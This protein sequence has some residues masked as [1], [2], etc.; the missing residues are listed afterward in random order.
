MRLALLGNPVGHSRSPAMHHAALAYHGVEGVYDA[1]EVDAAQFASAVSEIAVGTLTGVNVTMPHK[2]L[3]YAASEVVSAD[4]AM[5]RSV[6]TM[7]VRDQ[8]VMGI[9]TD[10]PAIRACWRRAE[11]PA[12]DVLI[13]G[14]GGAAAAALVAVA[15]I[16]AGRIS[17]SARRLGAAAQVLK[18]VGVTGSVVDWGDPFAGV[19]VNATPLGMSAE[20]LPTPMAARSTGLFDMAYADRPTPAVILATE[21]GVPFVSGIDMLVEQ[22]ALSFEWWT[23]LPAPRHEMRIAT[24]L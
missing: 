15:S 20:E 17:V 10:I 14:S 13:L 19:I 18:S 22:A 7:M 1:R 9:S 6:N 21:G 16:T 3:A 4:A 8:R 5:A 2:S 11:L 24:G 23:G 12:D